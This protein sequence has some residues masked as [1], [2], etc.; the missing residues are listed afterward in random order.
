MFEEL[1]KHV[2]D[3]KAEADGLR[4]Q[5]IIASEAAME[6]NVAAS[7]RLDTILA[8]ER[9]QAA[10]DRQSLLSQIT[11]LIMTQGEVQDTRLCT[12]INEV[13]QSVLSSKEAFEASRSK[14]SEGMDAWNDKETKLTEEVLRSREN[15]KSKLKEDW[16]V[17]FRNPLLG[18]SSG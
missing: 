5:L 2:N 15:L 8:E 4:R 6:A 13:Q 18:Y 1:I 7:T 14:Y 12:K 10:A 3:Q 16:M 17:S 11:S 9:Q